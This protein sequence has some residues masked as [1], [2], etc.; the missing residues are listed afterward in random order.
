MLRL[1]VQQKTAHK[2]IREQCKLLYYVF[3]MFPYKYL[4]YTQLLAKKCEY[5]YLI[6]NKIRSMV[7][8]VLYNI[9]KALLYLFTNFNSILIKFRH[10]FYVSVLLYNCVYIVCVSHVLTVLSVAGILFEHSVITIM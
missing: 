5:K 8:N 10:P 2:C 1:Y 3:L 7:L 6:Q 4:N 9:K